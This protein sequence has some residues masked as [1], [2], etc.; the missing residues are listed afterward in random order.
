MRL[1]PNAATRATL[2]HRIEHY[3]PVDD[4][5]GGPIRTA[6]AHVVDMATNQANRV[7]RTAGHGLDVIGM[8]S[9][10]LSTSDSKPRRR[11]G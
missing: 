6:L 10:A 8:T 1:L 11:C 5:V 9:T 4:G 2:A 3:F 7:K